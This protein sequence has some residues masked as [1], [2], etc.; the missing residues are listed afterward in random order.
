MGQDR[1]QEDPGIDGRQTETDARGFRAAGGERAH[2][3]QMRLGL[4]RDRGLRSDGMQRANNAYYSGSY[5]LYDDSVSRKL[6]FA[7]LWPSVVKLC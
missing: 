2:V 3:H 7:A 6:V 4:R 5:L 1:I